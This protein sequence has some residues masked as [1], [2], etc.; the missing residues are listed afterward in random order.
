MGITAMAHPL[1]ENETFP[2]LSQLS[3]VS[4]HTAFCSHLIGTGAY[5]K[6]NEGMPHCIS[7]LTVYLAV[8]DGLK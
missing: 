1:W 4:V 6:L 3:F 8:P 2:W 5:L 7:S